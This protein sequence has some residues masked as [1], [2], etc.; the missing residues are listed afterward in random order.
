[1]W[2]L[3]IEMDT[4]GLLLFHL[5]SRCRLMPTL[6][7]GDVVALV[8]NSI[9][10]GN[11]FGFSHAFLT[12]YGLYIRYVTDLPRMAPPARKRFELTEYG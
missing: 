2:S 4:F 7:D 8:V 6:R 3:S 1:M 9:V 10:A 12:A 5:P 11:L